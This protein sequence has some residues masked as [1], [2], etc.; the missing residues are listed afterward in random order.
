MIVDETVLEL[1]KVV[2][3]VAT[4]G[5]GLGGVLLGWLLTSRL[6]KTERRMQRI[7]AAV[8]TYREFL[9]GRNAALE[10]LLFA[11]TCLENKDEVG[12][13][14]YLKRARK[15]LDAL[16]RLV[17]NVFTADSISIRTTLVSNSHQCLQE[18][19]GDLQAHDGVTF[20]L[21][22]QQE[23]L[24]YEGIGE[25]LEDLANHLPALPISGELERR[26]SAI[27]EAQHKILPNP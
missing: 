9:V 27:R 18:M 22:R 8:V 21:H 14:T 16:D 13:L 25:A 10:E 17:W 26:A 11:A 6:A 23:R 19:F 4:A 3:L 15:A 5:V 2:E 12:L 1:E 7:A 20:D 24:A